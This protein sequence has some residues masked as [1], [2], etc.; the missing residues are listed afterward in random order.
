MSPV[1]SSEACFRGG[2]S[3]DLGTRHF[4]VKRV[5]ATIPFGRLKIDHEQVQLWIKKS[6]L[7]ALPPG[8]LLPIVLP[9]QST[10]VFKTRQLIRVGVGFKTSESATHYFWTF[11]PGR[12]MRVLLDFG[13]ELCS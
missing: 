3:L 5:R 6:V 11:R 4:G 8:L 1:L 2:A 13:Y 9:K 7:V 12:V 10:C